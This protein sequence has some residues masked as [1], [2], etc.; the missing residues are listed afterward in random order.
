MAKGKKWE[1][2]KLQKKQSLKKT[3]Q[4]VLK[5]RLN[6]ASRSIVKYLGD[7][8]VENLHSMRIAIRRLRYGMELF[9]VCFEREN[10]MIFYDLIVGLQN[11]S[12]TVRDL[13]VLLENIIRFKNESGIADITSIEKEI[14]NKKE[15]LEKELELKLR[16]FLENQLVKDFKILLA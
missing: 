4:I 2:K 6:F 5:N 15:I 14:T 16:Q 7:S 11:Q 9:V 3:S 10:Y 8:S 1:I 13:D 12:G